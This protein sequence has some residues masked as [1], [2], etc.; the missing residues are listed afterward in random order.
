MGTRQSPGEAM[1]VWAT[2]W[3]YNSSSRSRSSNNRCGSSTNSTHSSSITNKARLV[4]IRS[5]LLHL[6]SC[7]LKSGTYGK[8]ECNKEYVERPILTCSYIR[9]HLYIQDYCLKQNFIKAANA[10]AADTGVRTDEG[11][12]F[13]GELPEG[14]LMQWFASLDESYQSSQSKRHNERKKSDS[15]NG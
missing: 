5:R 7:H 2:V 6:R 14:L 8:C 12:P 13:G 9:L 4:R 10:V 3:P 11:V 1:G 15:T